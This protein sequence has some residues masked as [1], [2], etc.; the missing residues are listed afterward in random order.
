[1]TQYEVQREAVIPA[2]IERVHALIN[3][4]HKWSSWSPWEDVDP[5]MDRRFSGPEAGKDA[6][7]EWEGNRKAGKGSMTIV[8][9]APQRVDLVIDFDKP[10]KAHNPTSFILEPI[11]GGTHVRWVMSGEHKGMAAL[12]FKFMS[13]DK[14]LGPDFERGLRQL[15]AAAVA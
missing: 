11:D 14:F 10:F 7:Y 1:M 8:A 4:F 12:V 6:H 2:D 13:M 9:S 15:E 3:S 5:A